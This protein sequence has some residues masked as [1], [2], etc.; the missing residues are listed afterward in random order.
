[1]ASEKLLPESM[2]E[3]HRVSKLETLSEKLK[4]QLVKAKE[5]LQLTRTEHKRIEKALRESTEKYQAIFK[6]ARN[7]ITGG[8]DNCQNVCPFSSLDK[9]SIHQV[10]K[11][12]ISNTSIFNGFFFAMDDVMDYGGFV[13]TAEDWWNRD[14][15]KYPYD[16]TLGR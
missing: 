4:K 16:T 7:G 14:L 9:A 11:A 8:C 13:H 6:E 3:Q 12:T 1:M 5:E 15:S 2:K 10:V